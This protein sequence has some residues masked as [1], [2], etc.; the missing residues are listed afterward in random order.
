MESYNVAEAKTRLSEILQRV[1]EGEEVLLTRRG[2]PIA[3]VIPAART[4]NILGAGK[5][6]PNINLEVVARDDW[7]KPMAE[8]ESRSW[9]E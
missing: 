1:S 4:S 3:R 6:D 7:W 5:Q 2:R 9:Y 8:D